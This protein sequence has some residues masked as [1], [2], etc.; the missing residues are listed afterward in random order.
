MIKTDSKEWFIKDEQK[1]W[2]QGIKIDST[3]PIEK[4][5]EGLKNP[6]L[7]LMTELYAAMDGPN[8]NI[9]WGKIVEDGNWWKNTKNY[10]E[11]HFDHNDNIWSSQQRTDRIR[12]EAQEALRKWDTKTYY[13]YKKMIDE[14]TFLL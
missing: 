12:H 9:V 2:R 5:L 4:T 3:Q 8:S 13:L 10:V 1:D 7:W 14:D 6:S 11:F